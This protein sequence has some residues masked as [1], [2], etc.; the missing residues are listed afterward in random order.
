MHMLITCFLPL[1]LLM[2]ASSLRRTRSPPPPQA[3]PARTQNRAETGPIP[4]G[5]LQGYNPS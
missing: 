4:G 2:M 1:V 3:G 5:A